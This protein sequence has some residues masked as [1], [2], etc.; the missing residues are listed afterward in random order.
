MKQD[1]GE[2]VINIPEDDP[3]AVELM[4]HYL[5]TLDYPQVAVRGQDIATTNGFHAD[6]PKSPVP[7]SLEY[8]IENEKFIETAAPPSE[9]GG[10]LQSLRSK[11]KKKKKQANPVNGN[12][13]DTADL[14]QVSSNLVVHAK[15]Y[16]LGSK[17]GVHGLKAL[18]AEKFVKEVEHHW[19]SDDFL[20]AAQ[21]AYTSTGEDDRTIRDVV[22]KA[23]NE[24]PE[25]LQRKQ[26]QEVIR[27]LQLS[28]DLLML[29]L[30]GL[31]GTP[32]TPVSV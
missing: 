8:S 2:A 32:A 30:N 9:A 4:L 27:G 28:F 25:L 17:Y 20:G 19:D 31:G 11:K 22:L 18:S 29:R 10:E 14:P 13:I 23:I 16:S 15:V 24:H 5:Y 3:Q 6:E 12:G 21:E 26:V 7:V 1:D